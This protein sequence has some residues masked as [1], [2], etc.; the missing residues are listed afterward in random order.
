M[1]DGW[2]AYQEINIVGNSIYIHP[3]VNHSQ[4]FVNPDDPDTYTQ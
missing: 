4:N 2:L 3:M 1:S